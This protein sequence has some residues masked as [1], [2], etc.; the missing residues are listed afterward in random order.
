[1][2]F[3][4]KINYDEVKEETILKLV[5]HT[6]VTKENIYINFY[7]TENY[8]FFDDEYSYLLTEG[9]HNFPNNRYHL[10]INLK[11]KV[12]IFGSKFKR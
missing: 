6:F 4:F 3:K 11:R 5:S 8:I 1:M 9:V 12:V 2:R 7:R 10:V